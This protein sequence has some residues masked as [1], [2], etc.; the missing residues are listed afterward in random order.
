[1]PFQMH[2][3]SD[4]LILY[5]IIAISCFFIKLNKILGFR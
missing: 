3:R 1:M 4:S 5:N 2:L